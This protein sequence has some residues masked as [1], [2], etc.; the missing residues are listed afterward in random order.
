MQWNQS[1]FFDKAK[2]FENKE[3][4]N[5]QLNKYYLKEKRKGQMILKKKIWK[6]IIA[7]IMACALITGTAGSNTTLAASNKKNITA[8]SLTVKVSGKTAKERNIAGNIKPEE[9]TPDLD[10]M[11]DECEEIQTDTTTGETTREIRKGQTISVESISGSDTKMAIMSNGDLY[12]WGDNVYG[13]VGN[14]TTKDQTTPV[15]ILDNVKSVSYYGHTVSAITETGNLYCWG[16][17]TGGQVGNGTTKNQTTPVRVLGNVKSVSYYGYTV[18]AITETGNLYR[19]GDNSSGRIGNGTTE[20]QTTPIKVLDNVKSVTC[21][22]HT[23]SA[24]T[25]TGDLYCWGYNTGGQ[26]G[27]GT[28]ENQLTPVKVLSGVKSVT[29]SYDISYNYSM[30]AITENGDLYCWGD[31]YSGQIGNGTTEQQLT[32]VKV[33][34]EVKS[35]TSSSFFSSYFSSYYSMLVITENGDLYCWGDNSSGQIGNGTTENQLT[36]YKVL[37]GVKSVTSSSATSYSFSSVLAIKENGDLYCWGY[38]EDGQVGNGTT[39]NQL[40]PYKMLSGVKNVTFFYATSYFSSIAAITE[41]G[42]LYCWGYNYHGQT[43]NGTTKA[44]L[45]PYKVLSGV[46]SVTSSSATSYSSSIAAIIE[47]GDLYCWGYNEDGQ[48]GNG[49]T[50]NQLTPYK[51]SFE[52]FSDNDIAS[53]TLSETANATLKGNNDSFIFSGHIYLED[54]KTAS[55]EEWQSI[56]NSINWTSS[57]TSVVTDIKCQPVTNG[58]EQGDIEI[59][60]SVSLK[61]A[62][63]ATVTGTT[64]NGLTASCEVTVEDKGIISSFSL[65][66]TKTGTLD[67]PFP[68]FGTLTFNNDVEVT[69]ELIEKEVNAIRWASSD[70]DILPDS[71]IKCS[72]SN[73]SNSHSINL[74]LMLTAKKK[75]KVTIT[76]TASNGMTAS[77]EIMVGGCIVINQKASDLEGCTIALSGTIALEETTEA[78]EANLQKAIDSLKFE[79]SD[80]SKAMV[81]VCN[82]VK[83]KDYKSAALEIWTTLYN[84]GTATITVTAADG[85]KSKCEI[86]IAENNSGDITNYEGDYTSKM[87]EILSNKGTLNTLEYL[88]N[89]VNFTASTFVAEKDTQVGELVVKNIT[90]TFYRGWDGWRDLI[91]GSTSVKQAEE[92]IASLLGAYQVKIEGLSKIKTAHKYAK[93]LNN[94]FSDYA[95]VSNLFKA[96]HSDEIE[97]VRKYFT[98]SN[99]ARLLYE[100]KYNEITAPVNQI[101][102]DEKIHQILQAGTQSEVFQQGSEAAKSWNKMME[103]F[104]KSGE[105]SK[106]LKEGFKAK[107]GKLEI[108]GGLDRI[109]KTLD[110]VSFAQD[111]VNYFYQLESLLTADEMYCEMLLYIKENCVYNVVQKAA[112]NLYSV[113]NDGVE[114]IISDIS[115]K[116]INKTGNKVF[117]EAL[118]IACTKSLPFTIIK[119]GFDWGVTL[120]NTFFKT[121]TTQELKNS[122]RSQACLANCLGSWVQNNAKDYLSSVDTNHKMEKGKEL[123]YSLYMLWEAR[124]NAEETLQSLLKITHAGLSANYSVSTKITSTLESFQQNIFTEEN[125]ES[126]LA[127]SVSCPV[128]VEVYDE[129]GVK[130]LTV[131]DGTECQGYEKGIYY[132]CAYN[133]LASDYD[134]Y[135]YYS[136]DKNYNVKIVGNDLG[137]ADCSVSRVDDNGYLSEFYFENK[138]IDKNTVIELYNISKEGV[139]YKVTDLNGS[140]ISNSMESRKADKIATVSISLNTDSLELIAG[141]SQLLAVSFTPANAANQKVVW[142]SDND[143]VVSVNNDGVITAKAV[144][145]AVVTVSQGDLEQRCKITV[146]KNPLQ[147]NDNKN[148]SGSGTGGNTGSGGG[149]GGAGTTSTSAPIVTL[150][151]SPSPTPVTIATTEPT[152]KPSASTKPGT[153]SDNIFNNNSKKEI[154]PADV[155]LNKKTIIYSGKEKKP[156]VTVLS[157]SLE[158]IKDKEYTVSYSYNINVGTAYVNV[159]GKGDYYGS[160]T[161]SF[162][163]IPRGTSLKGKVK[164]RHKGFAVKWKKQPKSITGYQ[165]QYS[166]DKKFKGKTTVIRTVKKKSVTKL[167]VS[168]LKAKKKYYVRVRT[169]KTVKGKKYY[170]RWSKS[171]VVKTKK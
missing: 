104:T 127:I 72:S 167:T 69:K 85:H 139:G 51:V 71:A 132:Y 15:K 81:L 151:P 158:L 10:K 9:K 14:G 111:T 19:W 135:I 170:S 36:P 103:S 133:P 74:M 153:G 49:T 116:A 66:S 110:L 117:K 53:F 26:V 118:K 142:T 163:I 62:G 56:V 52:D 130:L 122:L 140:E 156:G 94:A 33:L 150:T 97:V 76:G 37:S 6:Q 22:Y 40:T 20:N 160:V 41:N 148:P 146:K 106:K 149:G 25:E 32:P 154:T 13:Q 61:S 96:M 100:G 12:C 64:S 113:I 88:C 57:D 165:V 24:I 29:S 90:N 119:A 45:T 143:A 166:T 31:N 3:V 155:T 86:T 157:G 47:N 7:A 46:K 136:E 144:G 145:T 65:D 171:K 78:S 59:A 124:K 67:N 120:S 50:K 89:D 77:C 138:K 95:R 38:N 126:L 147:D 169:Y 137:L 34:S 123:Y 99:L 75:G 1:T 73:T 129:K 70:R 54:G 131:K 28:T 161:K 92:I 11:L 16:Y 112:G 79:S 42:D 60:V 58:N 43:G 107:L 159:Y 63:K 164:P 80:D 98:E 68:V 91:D 108:G 109:G 18:S 162:K 168:K 48:V 8:A 35:V 84:K 23:V 141:N 152:L 105:I 114:G 82:A 93:M 5:K 128:D 134:K 125:M 4:K 30:S 55:S 39:E 87:S 121:G 83:S 115:E 102:Q 17:N 27:N 101:L 2:A 21:S 44:Q